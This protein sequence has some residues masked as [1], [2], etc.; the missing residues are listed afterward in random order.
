VSPV[1]VGSVQRILVL[2]RNRIG[3]CLLTTPMLRAL[4]RGF[5]QAELVAAIPESNRELLAANPHVDR[6]LVRPEIRS[7]AEKARFAWSLRRGGYDLIISLQEKSSFYAG[8]TWLATALNP[9]PAVTVG[10]E[11]PRTRRWYRHTVAI[12][13]ERHEVEKYLDIA[14]L[15]GCPV[16]ANPVLELAVG[17]EARQRVSERLSLLGVAADQRFLGINPGASEPEKRWDPVRFAAV[18]DRAF[19]ATG[20]PALVFG[21]PGD[22][23]AAAEICGA[24]RTHSALS[25]AGRATLGETAALLERC[26]ALVTGDTGP[27]H[28]AVALAVP[29]VTLFGPTSPAKFGPYTRRGVVLRHARPCPECS[30]PCLH[31][32]SAEECSEAIQGLLQ[33][34]GVV[35]AASQA[36]SESAGRN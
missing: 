26:A 6:I 33:G 7:W 13:P 12:L 23:A 22:Q 24:I 25:M 21:G 1:N 31:A 3:D 8:A 9:R 14:R 34:S 17:G 36:V 27:M 19:H 30:L 11:H 2:N 20:L 15:L 4:K 35:A 16:E 10:L 32:V 28:M 29:V 18:A 5:P